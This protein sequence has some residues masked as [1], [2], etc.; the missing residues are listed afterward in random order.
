MQHLSLSAPSG[1]ILSLDAVL[2]LLT[3]FACLG[4]K[5]FDRYLTYYGMQSF[6]LAIAAGTSAFVNHA[7]ALWILAALTFVLKGIAIPEVARRLLVQRLQLKRDTAIVVGLSTSLI[8]GAGLCA[9]AYLVIGPE[10]WATGVISKSVIP[11]S[12]AIVLLGALMT[13]VRRHRLAQLIGWLMME[14][15]VFLGGVTLASGFPFIVEAGIFLDVIAGVLIMLAMTT[16]VAERIT[17]P[18]R[19]HPEPS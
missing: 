3:A 2:M 13:V 12:T 1:V 8:L 15:G 10:S 6:L 9:F 19:Q 17:A 5:L 4:S 11:L 16:G 18:S 14:N 7:P